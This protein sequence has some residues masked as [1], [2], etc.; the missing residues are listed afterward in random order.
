M[1]DDPDTEKSFPM[2][3]RTGARSVPLSAAILVILVNLVTLMR[4]AVLAGQPENTSGQ[5]ASALAPHPEGDATLRRYIAALE[6][7]K[8][9]YAGMT[10]DFGT[11]VSQ[12]ASHLLDHIQLLG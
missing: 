1:R 7:G 11:A 9:D 8:P 3:F 5:P 10:A 12:Q 2:T 6:A 4:G